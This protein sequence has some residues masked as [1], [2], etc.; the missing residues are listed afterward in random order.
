MPTM[1]QSRPSKWWCLFKD[2]LYHADNKQQRL[3]DQINTTINSQNKGFSMLERKHIQLQKKYP[4]IIKSAY[5]CDTEA[6]GDYYR[7][8]FKYCDLM[9][10]ELQSLKGLN[11]L[12]IKNSEIMAREKSNLTAHLD[13]F[14]REKELK[15]SYK[16]DIRQCISAIDILTFKQFKGRYQQLI[17]HFIAK[18]ENFSKGMQPNLQSVINNSIAEIRVDNISEYAT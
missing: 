9:N 4:D 11:D 16:S 12:A 5:D 8:K 18:L 15:K 17:E 6:L 1:T 13:D 3:F 7:T 10:K 14:A 2:F